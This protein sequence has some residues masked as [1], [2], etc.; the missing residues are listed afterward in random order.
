MHIK[1]AY[2]L[3]VMPH[4]P[5]FVVG[6]DYERDLAPAAC[7]LVVSFPDRIFHARWNYGTAWLT[8][9][10]IFVQVCQN[11]GG[12][13]FS[14]LMLNIIVNCIPHWVPTM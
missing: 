14:N 1:I 11:V 2:H 10:F 7:R 12:A 4:P 5:R 3:S 8:A 6:G 13:F 9:Y